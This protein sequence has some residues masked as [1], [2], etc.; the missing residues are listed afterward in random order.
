LRSLRGVTL[1]FFLG[2]AVWLAAP[3][4]VLGARSYVRIHDNA[5]ST[6]ALRVSLRTTATPH[7]TTAWNPQPQAG[8]DQGPLINC[9]VDADGWLFAVF[10][11][12]LAYGLVMLLQR[13]IAGYFMYRLLRDRLSVGALASIC[14]GVLYSLFAQVTINGAWAGFTLY[15]GLSLS[16]L[17]LALWALDDSSRW[18]TRR[19]VAIAIGVGLLLGWTSHYSAAV[20]VVMGVGAWLLLRRRGSVW[21]ALSVIT[22]FCLA[23]GVAELPTLW[24]SA[25]NSGASN[26]SV[27]ALHGQALRAAVAE[28]YAHVRGILLDNWVMISA[29]I[30]GFAAT[31]F[32]S[33]ALLAAF[34]AAAAILLLVLASAVWVTW[35]APHAGPLAGFQLYRFYLL[36]PFA[37][38]VAGALGLDAIE[39]RLKARVPPGGGFRGSFWAAS[40]TLLVMVVLGPVAS[41]RVLERIVH[42]MRA[43]S[44]YAAVYERPVLQR[45]AGANIGEAPYRVV[46]VYAPQSS[47]PP[48]GVWSPQLFCQQPAYAWAYG[49][50]TA[51]GYVQ[52]YPESYQQYWARLTAPALRSDP[53]M[54]AYFWS[55]GGR[56]FLFVPA[57]GRPVG[58][59]QGIPLPAVTDL[60]GLC[61]QNLLSLDNVRYLISPVRL[62]GD[63]LSLVS[64]DVHGKP[65]PLYIYE[66]SRV[67]PRYFVVNATRTFPDARSLLTAMSTASLSDLSTVAYVQAKDST[68][69]PAAQSG[70]AAGAVGVQA[71]KADDVSLRVTAR[72]PSVLV[73]TMNYS[74]Y[75]RAYV[76]G[77]EARVLQADSTFVGV[78]VSAGSHQVELR[79]QPPYAWLFPG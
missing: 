66:N 32:R 8:L 30:L 54:R 50:E 49:L 38:I 2:W 15:F 65:W 19:R 5:D 51:D 64:A 40:L 31:R 42:E 35:I 62:S 36:A 71:Y 11:G 57:P 73:C 47:A 55:F 74:P 60:A 14:A 63:G 17:P 41:A 12:W 4:C 53:A 26:R 37:L 16:S 79:Y 68:G 1:I 25:L 52:F 18:S 24:S 34:G 9:G 76:D 22:A 44:T 72:G 7:L 10:P 13:F 59:R 75:W 69:L 33:R 56:V 3:Y 6:L 39:T 48:S 67:L 43:G 61:N 23:W 28:Q 70:S 58:D 20:F 27:W 78:S 45:L 46:T 77:L 21:P 29:A